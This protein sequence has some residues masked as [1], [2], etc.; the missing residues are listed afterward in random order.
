MFDTNLFGETDPTCQISPGSFS[1]QRRNPGNKEDDVRATAPAG[2][3]L[4]AN[5]LQ[6]KICI[7][8]GTRVFLIESS[9]C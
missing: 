9:F 6:E 5:E 1:Q 8:C 4:R 3:V 2:L 7:G